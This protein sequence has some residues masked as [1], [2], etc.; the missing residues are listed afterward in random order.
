VGG[1]F[2]KSKNNLF[3][4]RKFMNRKITLYDPDLN[5]NATNYRDNHI[6]KD[7]AEIILHFINGKY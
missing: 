3:P 7:A 4:T 6:H 5:R 2:E 1:C